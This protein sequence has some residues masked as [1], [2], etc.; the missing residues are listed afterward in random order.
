M[1]VKANPNVS[2]SPGLKESSSVISEEKIHKEH[3]EIKC[4][5]HLPRKTTDCRIRPEEFAECQP[6]KFNEFEVTRDKIKN[7]NGM[8][9]DKE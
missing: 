2:F 3:K 1:P 5:V 4:R 8:R 9:N 6:T 7:M